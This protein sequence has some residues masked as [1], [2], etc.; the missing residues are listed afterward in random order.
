MFCIFLN[1]VTMAM[2]HTGKDCLYPSGLSEAEASAFDAFGAAEDLDTA[3]GKYCIVQA[4]E[5]DAGI[6]TTL[7]M[8]NYAFVVI[9][10]FEM[11]VRLGGLGWRG[12]KVR[13][14]CCSRPC[15]PTHPPTGRQL[16]PLRRYHRHPLPCGDPHVGRHRLVWRRHRVDVSRLPAPSHLQDG[17]VV[18]CPQ[19]HH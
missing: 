16:Q 14:G 19:Q 18:D 3:S 4:I 13:R 7:L 1:T 10:T 9:F 17:Q 2:T 12:Y 15:P 5:M 8:C 6:S 11:V